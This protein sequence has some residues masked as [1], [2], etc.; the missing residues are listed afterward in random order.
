MAED[1]DSPQKQN[2]PQESDRIDDLIRRGHLIYD[3]VDSAKLE[4]DIELQKTI[5]T[6]IGDQLSH[7]K[8]IQKLGEAKTASAVRVHFN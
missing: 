5:V 3:G 7:Y 6:K 8:I 4:E 1:K 2:S